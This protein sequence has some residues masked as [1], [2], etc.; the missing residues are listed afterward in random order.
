[1]ILKVRP[2]RYTISAGIEIVI[3]HKETAKKLG[4]H[5]N[6]RLEI[7]CLNCGKKTVAVVEISIGFVE[8]DEIAV[9]EEVTQVIGKHK[10]QKV[11][12]EPSFKPISAMYVTKKLK[13][14]ALSYT[15]IYAII[16]DIVQNKLTDIEI[17]YFCS[18]VGLNDMN[19][20][21]VYSL[22]KAMVK[23]GEE[24]KWNNRFVLDKHCCGGVAG[25][26]TTPLVVSIVGS[27][28]EE[29]GINAVLPNT[30]SRAITSAAGTS[31]DIEILTGIEFT[32]QQLKK[33]I[34]KIGA[35][36]VW[37]G[38]LG[39]APADDKIIQV[40][41]LI[42][43]ESHEQLV[44]SILAKKIAMGTTHVVMEIPY[45]STAKFTKKNAQHIKYL[46]NKISSRFN[47]KIKCLLTDGSQPI[48][49]G[50]GPCLEMRDIISVLRRTE[51]RPLDLEER[52]LLLSTELLS[53]VVPIK[54]ATELCK[55]LLNSGKAYEKFKE[56]ILTQGGS[57][58]END[59]SRKLEL[60]RFH[61][62]IKSNKSGKITEIDNKKVAYISRLLGCPADKAAGVYLHAHVGTFIDEKDNLFTL[63][64]E[65]K[66]KL[67]YTKK[68]LK[69]FF[70]MKIE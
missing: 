28:I 22:T 50:I 16:S 49:N 11:F 5:A 17:A 10:N 2:L 41:R 45:G 69:K 56:I 13:K 37:N 21:E 36:F 70:P 20:D 58:N 14:H 61:E 42:N 9:S 55:M 47:L 63:Y 65:T 57:D 67:D 43:L 19:L 18:A 66:D 59:I 62:T 31:D 48:G 46:M 3:L 32:T 51:S 4:V 29:L 40:E 38:I 68:S 26:R 15:E 44:A 39:L 54:Q 1:M 25:I 23:T 60:G 30:S 6:D 27:A 64:A 24:I 8:K 33:I 35:C 52:S 53:F 7:K 12:V 34:K